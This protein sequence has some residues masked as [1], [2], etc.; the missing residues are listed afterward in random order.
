MILDWLDMRRA[1]WLDIRL[2]VRMAVLM[3]AQKVM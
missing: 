1:D 2:V 3:A